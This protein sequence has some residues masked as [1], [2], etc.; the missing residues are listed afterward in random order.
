MSSKKYLENITP[1]MSGRGLI[2]IIRYGSQVVVSL[3]NSVFGGTM[4][5]GGTI[6]SWPSEGGVKYG[7]KSHISSQRKALYPIIARILS[8]QGAEMR[9]ALFGPQSTHRTLRGWAT[10]SANLSSSGDGVNT[11]VGAMRCM[12]IPSSS[13]M[14]RSNKTREGKKLHGVDAVLPAPL[15]PVNRKNIQ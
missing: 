14:T 3:E 6:C 2:G 13:V 8:D 4:L 5:F 10:G 12:F 7:L 1:S 11:E 9:R 15:E